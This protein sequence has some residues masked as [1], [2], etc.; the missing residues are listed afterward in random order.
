MKKLTC[1]LGSLLLLLAV[2]TVPASATTFTL[3]NFVINL[4]S[5]DSGLNI[6]TSHYEETSL[7]YSFTIKNVGETYSFPLFN[8]WTNNSTVS[9]KDLDPRSISVQFFFSEPQPAFDGTA[10]G[11]TVGT[12]GSYFFDYAQGN[13]N[14]DDPIFLSFGP[15]NDGLLKLELSNVTFNRN[16]TF[17]GY[18]L[19]PGF[20]HRVIVQLTAT[21]EQ[22]ASVPEPAT[23]LLLGFGLI[24]MAAFGRKRLF[25][26]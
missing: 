6:E 16:V 23:M 20:N 18:G 7:P 10:T 26:K 9:S 25:N 3:D 1:L 19:N 22:A 12:R 14:W 2:S 11:D 21:Y 13:V 24:G 4:D 8:I 5:K 17:I 15:L